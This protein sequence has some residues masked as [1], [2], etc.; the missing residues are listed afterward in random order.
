MSQ[1]QSWG[2]WFTSF[3]PY[4]TAS[5][6]APPPPLTPEERKL[7]LQLLINATTSISGSYGPDINKINSILTAYPDLVNAT[8][9]TV[10]EGTITPLIKAIENYQV[11]W[12]NIPTV[13][14]LE[15]RFHEAI[16]ILLAKGANINQ[17]GNLTA[18]SGTKYYP[19]EYAAIY[20]NPDV[21][22]LL[23]EYGANINKSCDTCPLNEI[24]RF[25]CP[26]VPI[27]FAID[28]GNIEN[29]AWF[30]E[31]GAKLTF[32]HNEDT[33]LSHAIFT[34]IYV[35]RDRRSVDLKL[36]MIR[37]LI[38]AGCRDILSDYHYKPNSRYALI[39]LP[40][41]IQ[42]LMLQ[43]LKPPTLIVI[44]RN[45]YLGLLELLLEILTPEELRQRSPTGETPYMVALQYLGWRSSTPPSPA[46]RTRIQT[47][48]TR[49]KELQEGVTNSFGR[50]IPNTNTY[51]RR[52][53]NV[54]R[55]MQL[56]KINNNT[57]MT[58]SNAS[59]TSNELASLLPAA[60]GGRTRRRRR[61][62]RR[63]TRHK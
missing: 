29:V 52:P 40:I 58:S 23:V 37:L 16:R 59:I 4:R 28:K 8:E 57:G 25:D 13:P 55:M 43:T 49:L 51:G 53:R 17:P 27:F 2:N 10:F 50:P 44:N 30:I 3:I 41:F 9:K 11:F 33:L 7:Q 18:T 46:E 54:A 12:R 20:A 38:E 6:L 5:V 34:S 60:H 22:E 36:D 39:D 35:R 21:L 42:A 63:N 1:K 31:N 26:P 56:T 15:E 61:N 48:F 14:G 19:I 62:N 32:S 24:D 45:L 47:I